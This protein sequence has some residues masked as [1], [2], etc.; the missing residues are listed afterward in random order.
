MKLRIV[1]GFPSAA[2]AAMAQ[3][4]ASSPKPAIDT[5]A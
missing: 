2:L 3:A 4:P 5:A 1:I